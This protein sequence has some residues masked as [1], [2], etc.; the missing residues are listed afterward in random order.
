MRR[1]RSLGYY[2][3]AA[4]RVTGLVLLVYLFVHLGTLGAVLAGEDSFDRALAFFRNPLARFFELL[5]VTIVVFHVLNGLR[6]IC[7]DLFPAWAQDRLAYGVLVL[8][9]LSLV[10]SIPFFF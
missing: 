9:A 6:L 7:L 5:L 2:V 4:H 3:W 10:L 1:G 8:T